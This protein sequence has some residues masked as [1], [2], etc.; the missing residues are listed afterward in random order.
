[1]K[2]LA[3]S[4]IFML[5]SVLCH[6]ATY[7]WVGGSGVWGTSAS[8]ASSS[9]GTGAVLSPTTGDI[10]IFDA[11]SGN[12]TVTVTGLSIAIAQ[13]QLSGGT[14]VTLNGI[15]SSLALSGDLTIAGSCTLN[16]GGNIIVVSGNLAG[17]GTHAGLGRIRIAA[18]SRTV[19]ANLTLGNL[20]IQS[21]TFNGNVTINGDLLHTGTSTANGNTVT[22]GGNLIA[23]SNTSTLNTGSSGKWV[24]TGSSTNQ[25]VANIILSAS[26]GT[27]YVVGDVINFTPPPAGGITAVGV[28]TS[29]TS[30]TIAGVGITDPGS[31]YTSAPTVTGITSTAGTGA[32]LSNITVALST[33]TVK[34]TAGRVNTIVE[35]LELNNSNGSFQVANNRTFTISGNLNFNAGNTNGILAA[36]ASSSLVIGNGG[37]TTVTM[38]A[39]NAIGT[40][41]SS[42]GN[43]TINSSTTVGTLYFDQTN[44]N[45]TNRFSQFTLTAGNVT[46]GNTLHTN[47]NFTLTAGT[48]TIGA[49]AGLLINTANVTRTSGV[50][51]ASNTGSTIR[52]TSNTSF[53]IPSGLFN[54]ATVTNMVDSATSSGT[55]THTFGSAISV[56]NYKLAISGSATF[57]VANSSNLTIASGGSITRQRTT[58][59]GT[60]SLGS[61]PTFAGT[62]SV[63][64]LGSQ[65]M[66]TGVELPASSGVLTD[67]TINNSAGITLN[68]AA[69]V[70]GSLYLYSGTFTNGSNLTMAA[71]S[72]IVRGQTGSGTSGSLAA[73]PTLGS[74]VNITALG[75]AAIT[76][77]NELPTGWLQA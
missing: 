50:I 18:N 66:T 23:Y 27:G 55:I 5:V 68:A 20:Q 25:S 15:A 8:F 17:S 33:S 70:N 48:L 12:P 46:L 7:Y 60:V 37:N 40:V 69:T 1:M 21:T 42:S 41:T 51:N 3:F 73:I 47:S 76:S 2:K 44:F 22:I 28:V 6:A 43:L 77:G 13:I 63:H 24:L 11:N 14:T 36:N 19:A 9:G 56:T 29:V 10:L 39:T 32:V 35:N 61:A 71:G 4:M 59:T 67:L 72:T 31:G 49:D 52:F 75:T 58:S 16:D 74:N 57:S 53:T 65:A 54:P 64:Y 30:G 62:A 38:A 34:Y 45:T 26:T